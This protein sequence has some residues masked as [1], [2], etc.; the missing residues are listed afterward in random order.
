MGA[1]DWLRP[2]RHLIVLFA[3]VTLV[4]AAALLWLGW[5]F[6]ERDQAFEERQIRARLEASAER[7][8]S[9]IALQLDATARALPDWVSNPP[10]T[11]KSDAVLVRIG[12][13]GAVAKAGGPLLFTPTPVVPV[14]G[15]AIGQADQARWAEA[16]ALEYLE[17]NFE[18]AAPSFRA[19]SASADPYTRALALVAT[20]RNLRT[21]GRREE[22]LEIYRTLAGLTTTPV[23]GEP[24]DLVARATECKLLEELGRRDELSR[25]A[26]ALADDLARG[27][28]A[29]DGATLEMRTAQ[30]RAWTP[31]DISD[32]DLARAS[33]LESFWTDR[34]SKAV[35]YRHPE[36]ES[37]HRTT[38][39]SFCSGARLAR[40]SSR[41][42]QARTMLP[43][44]GVGTDHPGCAYL[45]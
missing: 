42:P 32:D 13:G 19:V 43:V 20:A 15:Q 44:L 28:W 27:R 4:P 26:R 6:F 31:V 30:V 16:E 8:K 35:A 45:V 11:L 5:Q 37:S 7:V 17:R 14:K 33:A 18:K 23:N 2:P 24:S 1:L 25:T 38:G 34:Q 22:A 36:A 21:L 29:I 41:W 40:T 12:P 39:A 9:G 3:G 10:D